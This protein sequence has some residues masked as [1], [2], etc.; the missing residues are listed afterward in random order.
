MIF[1]KNGNISVYEFV[2]ISQSVLLLNI[3]KR[4][5]NVFFFKQTLNFS[6]SCYRFFK[7]TNKKAFFIFV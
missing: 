7:F 5:T 2:K 6:K 1:L 3:V 4:L